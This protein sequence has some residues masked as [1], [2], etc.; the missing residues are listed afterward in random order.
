[1]SHLD[2]KHN[3]ADVIWQDVNISLVHMSIGWWVA[4]KMVLSL[5]QQLFK[6]VYICICG[7]MCVCV[8]CDCMYTC[9]FIQWYL[10]I[11]HYDSILHI[12]QW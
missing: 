2:A 9:V 1:M 12:I 5:D 6:N 10:F 8:M 3:H 11:V 4:M 7:W